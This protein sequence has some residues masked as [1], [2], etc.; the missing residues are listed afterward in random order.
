MLLSYS[1]GDGARAQGWG[2]VDL[3][4]WAGQVATVTIDRPEVLNAIDLATESELQRIWRDL[5]QRDDARVVVL[6]CACKRAFCV[7]TDVKGQSAGSGLDYWARACPGGFG[8]IALRDTLNLPAIARVNGFEMVLGCDIVV[9]CD[10][11]SFGLPKLRVGRLPLDGD[12][13]LR[14]R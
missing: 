8:G 9:A 13:R 2:T 10:E 6:T 5:E 7:G 12:M 11:A 1:F 3:A 4:V 14:R